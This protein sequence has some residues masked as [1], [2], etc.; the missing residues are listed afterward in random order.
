MLVSKVV[1]YCGSS[2]CISA[3]KT[4]TI[5]GDVSGDRANVFLQSIAFV[6]QTTDG[7]IEDVLQLA[8]HGIRTGQ[9]SRQAFLTLGTLI[10]RHCAK[11]SANCKSAGSKRGQMFLVRMLN[12]CDKMED[13]RRVEEILMAIKGI[14]NAKQPE[15]VRPTLI[16]CALKSTHSNITIA[17]FD[18]LRGMRCQD[19]TLRELTKVVK[20][21]TIDVEKRIHA[22]R[23]SI[24][25]PT[26][27]NLEALVGVY[28]AADPSEQVA[29]YMWSYLSNLNESSSP[30]NAKVK[31]YLAAIT[32][33]EPLKEPGSFGCCV[34]GC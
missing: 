33:G 28:M 4:A 5:E 2:S 8:E 25:C 21:T 6:A 18:A 34:H 3:V 30:D 17:A 10:S 32:K 11:S 27:T 12:N 23:A 1:R 24:K 19:A 29:S 7:I 20:D 15:S 31:E 16:Q 14:G 13:Y 9:P 22:F 26:Y